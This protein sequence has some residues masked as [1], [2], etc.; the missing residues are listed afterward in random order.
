M[1]I[2]NLVIDLY[3]LIVRAVA[4]ALSDA[5]FADDWGKFESDLAAL[6]IDLPGEPAPTPAPA[7]SVPAPSVQAVPRASV[8]TE[9]VVRNPDGSLSLKEG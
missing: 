9:E 6:G 5:E 4:L 7:Q 8:A 2:V 3:H 1:E